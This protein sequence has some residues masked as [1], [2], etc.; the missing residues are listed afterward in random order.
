MTVQRRLL[1][2]LTRET[3]PR[4]KTR[5]EKGLEGRKRFFVNVK[6]SLEKGKHCLKG[7]QTGL[8]SQTIIWENLKWWKNFRF[9][10]TSGFEKT[11]EA[12]Y[13]CRDRKQNLPQG[14][15]NLKIQTIFRGKKFL[16]ANKSNYCLLHDKYIKFKF[17][18]FIFWPVRR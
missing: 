10:K 8:R 4:A 14:R 12:K 16:Q 7:R 13:F 6:I 15:K 17:R 11:S 1:N 9:W 5:A 3:E 2:G 18:R